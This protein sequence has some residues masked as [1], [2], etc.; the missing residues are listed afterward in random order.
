[1]TWATC[2]DI[3]S[4][5][6]EKLALHQA[7]SDNIVDHAINNPKSRKHVN[8]DELE[9]TLIKENTAEVEESAPKGQH[10]DWTSY[11]KTYGQFDL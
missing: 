10:V 5:S 11:M 7:C 8:W 4:S 1:M 6:R 3:L 2:V 9:E